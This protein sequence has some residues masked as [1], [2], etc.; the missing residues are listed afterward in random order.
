MGRAGGPARQNV[1]SPFVSTATDLFPTPSHPSHIRNPE[2]VAIEA[3][4]VVPCS[5]IVG[6]FPLSDAPSFRRG[7]TDAIAGQYCGAVDVSHLTELGIDNRHGR[8]RLAWPP[9]DGNDQYIRHRIPSIR[10]DVVSSSSA[11]PKMI[12]LTQSRQ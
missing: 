12:M 7:L 9:M 4:V 2:R 10:T 11:R 6:A 8:P 3:P 5:R 1:R